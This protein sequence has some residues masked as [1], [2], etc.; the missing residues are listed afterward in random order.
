MKSLYSNSHFIILG[1]SF[2]TENERER[3]YWIRD[4]WHF[5]WEVAILVWVCHIDLL[6][7]EPVIELEWGIKT[8][9]EQ[10]Q[11]FYDIPHV[12]AAPY[13]LTI[14]RLCARH[15]ARLS[16]TFDTNKFSG[17]HFLRVSIRFYSRILWKS[18]ETVHSR[19]FGFNGVHSTLIDTLDKMITDNQFCEKWNFLIEASLNF[20]ELCVSVFIVNPSFGTKY[21]THFAGTV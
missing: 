2:G 3:E 18:L 21:S 11:I 8:F 12:R 5:E 4:D 7:N 1:K 6:F 15:W 14:R 20:W 19:M 16:W 13:S 10:E 9:E 17:V